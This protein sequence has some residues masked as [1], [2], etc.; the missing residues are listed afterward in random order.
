MTLRSSK[1]HIF[2]LSNFWTF[3][4]I[5]SRLKL[6][7]TIHTSHP[8][9]LSTPRWTLSKEKHCAHRSNSVKDNFEIQKRHFEVS[10]YSTLVQINLA[11]VQFYDRM[12]AIR[13]RQKHQRKETLPFITTNNPAKP[14]LK[15]ILM[16]QWHLNSRSTKPS[17][18]FQTTSDCILQEG[19]S[20]KNILVRAKN[21]SFIHT[22][23][24]KADFT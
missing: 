22:T 6:F 21:D 13:P 8:A 19:K 4:L 11:T 2:Q 18:H 5:S 20:L 15:K 24:I 17:S 14:N 1:D 3:E 12:A 7:S 9:T 23:I 16:K 10:L